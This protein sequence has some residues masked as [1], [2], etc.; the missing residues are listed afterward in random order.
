MKRFLCLSTALLAIMACTP[1]AETESDKTDWLPVEA[2]VLDTHKLSLEPGDQVYLTGRVYPDNCDLESVSWS[3]SDT[4]VATVSQEGLVSAV[5]E[6]T[7]IITLNCD[8][9]TDDCKVTVAAARIPVSSVTLDNTSATL[10]EGE[11]LQLTATV[12]P[13]DAT[14]R[15]VKW[16]SSDPSTVSVDNGTV[17][18]VGLGTAT[19]TA[20]AGGS[21]AKCEVTVQLPGS[22]EGF[23][24]EDLK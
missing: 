15:T 4:A 16:A 3:S 5:A 7:C 8:G 1:D 21:S 24:Y 17:K 9:M 12:L 19:V 10:D 20:T 18:A 14:D 2:V 6:G 11:K 23:D 22:N 13:D